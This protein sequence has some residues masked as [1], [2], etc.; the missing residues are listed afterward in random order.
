MLK[1]R[2]I[3]PAIGATVFV[4]GVAAYFYFNRAGDN[5]TPASISQVIPD[6]AYMAAF[7][8]TDNNHWEKLKQFGTAEAQQVFE[9]RIQEFQQKMLAES[10]VDVDK[11]LKPWVGNMMMAFIP[12][13]NAK[14]PGVL[15]AIAIKDKMSALSFAN[16]LKND[17]KNKSTETEYK[18]VKITE[19]TSEKDKTPVYAAVLKDAYLML[20]SNKKAIE[21]SIE[22]I[23]G[24]P[25]FA[26]KL[27][28]PSVLSQA[29]GSASL[30]R[31]YL[32]DYAGMVQS[33]TRDLK[34]P[35]SASMLEQLKKVKSAIATISVDPV[36]L[37]FK[38]T[39]VVDPAAA[40]A[41]N[42]SPGTVAAQFPSDTF[43]F[44]SG[45]NL[46]SYWTQVTE[47]AKESPEMT[48]FFDLM[49]G[50]TQMAGLDLDKD[51]FSWMN[52]EFAIGMV[53]VNKGMMAQ[54]GFGQAMVF[55]TS[56]RKTAEATLTKL[57]SMAKSQSLGVVQRDVNGKK[58]TEWQTPQGALLGHG[59]LNDNTLFVAVGDPRVATLSNP[60]GSLETSENFKA[61]TN[62]LPKQNL[63]YFYM[64]MEKTMNLVNKF[65]PVSQKSQMDQEATAMLNSIRSVG[66]TTTQVDK[67]TN[68]FEM[69][70]ALR[71]A[72]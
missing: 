67:T 17:P 16:K 21:H 64:D 46:S 29:E 48:Q 18:G 34:Q 19:A 41:F 9:K 68:Q 5:A 22:T 13:S 20:A 10:N 30:A 1:K 44:V 57:D 38:G 4:G 65:N 50:G 37:R 42:P 43:A 26:T 24:S 32:P 60:A 71:S 8:S 14:E 69:V 45:A 27:S 40:I 6:E 55:S 28:D 31:V 7:I 59:W 54:F 72:K 56:D 11:D 36:G 3:L 61:V 12:S 25:S 66:G 70:F 58:I 23:Q 51:I 39:V 47:Q 33:M 53:P 52:G 49:R 15:M 2:L 62:A 35:I 63:G